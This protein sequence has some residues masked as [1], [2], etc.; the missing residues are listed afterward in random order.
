MVVNVKDTGQRG[1]IGVRAACLT[2][3]QCVALK[4]FLQD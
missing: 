4:P 1:D 3:V 2:I